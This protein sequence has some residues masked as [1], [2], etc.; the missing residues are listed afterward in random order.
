MERTIASSLCRFKVSDE[1]LISD[2]LVKGRIAESFDENRAFSFYLNKDVISGIQSGTPVEFFREQFIDIRNGIFDDISRSDQAQR[3]IL[4]SDARLSS[5]L[6]TAM[7][8]IHRAVARIP[9]ESISGRRFVV[10]KEPLGSP[11]IYHISRETTVIAHVGQGPPWSEIPSI[12]L[13]LKTFDMLLAEQKKSNNDFFTAFI[14]LLTIEERAVQTGYTHVEVYPVKV[15]LSLNLLVDRVIDYATEREIEAEKVLPPKKKIPRFT[16]EN[17]K[18]FMRDLNARVKGDELNFHYEK[19]LKAVK[20][21]EQNARR[22]KKNGDPDSLREVVRILVAASG[23]DIHEIRNRANI[24]LERVFAPKEFDAPLATH[25]INL[26]SGD[27][28]VFSF[29]LPGTKEGYFL[30]I[31]KNRYSGGLFLEKDISFDDLPLAYDE[32]ILRHLPF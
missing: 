30:R 16:N 29:R 24:I 18:K 23:H 19:N 1:H 26:P 6:V 25:F 4:L 13:G 31:Y 8:F 7:A 9:L 15:S 12:Y 14:N 32:E 5:R 2:D 28:H 21:L 27:S 3:N 10:I 20:S 22:Y 11:T 17:R